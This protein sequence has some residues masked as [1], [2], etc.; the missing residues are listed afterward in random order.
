MKRITFLSLT[1]LTICCSTLLSQERNLE[2]G[3]WGIQ[4]GINPLGIHNESRL[5]NSISLRSEIGFGF[6]FSGDSWAI[7]PQIILEPRYYY[8]IKRRSNHNKQTRN[9]SG[10]YLSINLNYLSGDLS[11]TSNDIYVYPTAHI[12][13]MYGLRRNI[14]KNFNF[15]FAFG[16]GYGWTFEEYTGVNYDTNETYIESNTTTGVAYGLRLAIGYIF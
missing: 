1:L 10:N 15:E 3:I 12:I 16:V 6:G 14:G 2:K 4:I 7:M 13:P 5:A 9:N 11:V 8:N